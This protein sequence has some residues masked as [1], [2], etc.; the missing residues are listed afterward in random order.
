MERWWFF[1]HMPVFLRT[2]RRLGRLEEIGHALDYL[3]VQQGHVLVQD[4]YVPRDA[5]EDAT[6]QGVRL[7]LDLSDLRRE[8]RHVPPEEFLL[9][10][11]ATPGY[12]Y[13]TPLDVPA[14]SQTKDQNSS[15]TI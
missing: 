1:R 8:R 6:P 12:E 9:R 15:E 5:V 13:T 10:Q 11:G 14:F 3:H 4:W 2:G 7:N